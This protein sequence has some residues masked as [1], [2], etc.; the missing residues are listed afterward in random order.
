MKAELDSVVC[1]IIFESRRSNFTSQ[2]GVKMI[3]DLLEEIGYKSPEGVRMTREIIGFTWFTDT[4]GTIGIVIVKH[5]NEE[6][7]YIGHGLGHNEEDD[8]WHIADWGASFPLE[9][10]R[11]V[12]AQF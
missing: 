6:K 12:I 3:T 2:E 9:E 11:K 10:A 1:D 7:A 4:R 5:H 8:I